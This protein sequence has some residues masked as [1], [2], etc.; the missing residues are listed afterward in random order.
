ME[1][2]GRLTPAEDFEASLTQ[3]GSSDE[4]VAEE[5]G[6]GTLGICFSV[7]TGSNAAT[8]GS[9]A[10][11]MPFCLSTPASLDAVV[12]TG[13]AAAASSTHLRLVTFSVVG[14]AAEL[15]GSTP[16]GSFRSEI[17][18]SPR[19]ALFVVAADGK[20]VVASASPTTRW[21]AAASPEP[22]TT[23]STGPTFPAELQV[24]FD[25]DSEVVQL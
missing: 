10:G 6:E 15:V 11:K 16:F 4:V 8:S 25:D 19:S 14:D 13:A 22:V 24:R 12:V 21:S 5:Q 20:S 7:D 23:S 1:D 2:S 3:G 9:A 18:S 17:I